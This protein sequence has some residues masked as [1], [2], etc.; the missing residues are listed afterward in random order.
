MSP[1]WAAGNARAPQ[2]PQARE[3]ANRPDRRV[4]GMSRAGT[5]PAPSQNVF[6]GNLVIVHGTG[7][8]SGVFI[9]N[10]TPGPGNPPQIAE[11]P[12]GVTT[13]P[14]GNAIGL[15]KILMQGNVITMSA[16]IFRTAAT[17]P[18]IQLDGGRDAFFVYDAAA[19]LV[20]TI[21]PIATNDGLG[22]TVYAGIVNYDPALVAVARM[23]SGQHQVGTPGQ[24]AGTGGASPGLF[25]LNAGTAGIV[26]VSS[27]LTATGDTAAALGCGSANANGGQAIVTANAPLVLG[28]AS[29]AFT[30]QSNAALISNSTSTYPMAKSGTTGD[31]NLYRV[32]KIRA[33]NTAD[34]NVLGTTSIGASW[35]VVSGI[36]Y[37]IHVYTIFSTPVATGGSEQVGFVKTGA[38]VSDCR[39][40]YKTF[41]NANSSQSVIGTSSDNTLG[42]YTTPVLSANTTYQVEGN[43]MV[44]FSGAGT[45]QFSVGLGTATGMTLIHPS[46]ATLEPDG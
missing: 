30:Q 32:G 13:D 28:S 40:Q 8:T 14:Y 10:G 6:I 3:L 12:S 22:H 20:D 46:F 5:G 34:T 42:L 18:L 15:S 23:L 35:N 33:Y 45:V 9:Y 11:V 38:T 36:W 43:G 19:N 4:L 41:I 25:G 29:G 31:A 1:W 21:T 2:G 44:K 26:L 16:G 24:I 7:P 37:E 27:G 39:I 17:A